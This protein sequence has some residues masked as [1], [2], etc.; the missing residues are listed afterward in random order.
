MPVRLSTG[1]VHTVPPDLRAALVA[2]SA[3]HAVWQDIT[4][5]A[6]NEWICWVQSVK[7][8]ETRRQHVE[9]VCIHLKE[10]QH[11]PCCWPGCPHR[12]TRQK[13]AACPLP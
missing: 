3:A 7:K 13:A 8:P 10:G 2:D 5:L 1:V 4:P 11:R 6:R 12:G 9:R